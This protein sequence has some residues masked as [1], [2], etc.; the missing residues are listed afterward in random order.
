M[1]GDGCDCANVAVAIAIAVL[2]D[3]S[4]GCSS[5]SN[6]TSTCMSL[7][8]AD[9]D[10]IDGGVPWRRFDEVFRYLP[11]VPR[12]LDCSRFLLGNNCGNSSS[13]SE[14]I[15]CGVSEDDSGT[16]AVALRTIFLRHNTQN[17]E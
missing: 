4:D 8:V 10:P 17:H 9:F 2:G 15:T 6:C 11:A 12:R 7:L 14:T 1:I 13:G 5:V 16:A 3:I